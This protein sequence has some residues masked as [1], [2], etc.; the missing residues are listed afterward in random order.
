MKGAA[1]LPENG[2]LVLGARLSLAL[3]VLVIPPFPPLSGARSSHHNEEQLVCGLKWRMWPR[4]LVCGSDRL[5]RRWSRLLP[6]VII[7][8]ADGG[9][10][11][12]AGPR[13]PTGEGADPVGAPAVQQA[14]RSAALMLCSGRRAL[15]AVHL[16]LAAVSAPF[17]LS[18]S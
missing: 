13:Q 14:S 6:E 18:A 2:A 5:A 3:L 16:R 9:D 12:F 17:L 11:P 8:L 10:G 15:S 7:R 1:A 4:V